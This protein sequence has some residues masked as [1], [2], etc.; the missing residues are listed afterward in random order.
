MKLFTVLR[1]FQLSV[2]NSCSYFVNKTYALGQTFVENIL[3]VTNLFALYTCSIKTGTFCLVNSDIETDEKEIR[4]E[5]E[6]KTM[7]TN[8]NYAPIC[9]IA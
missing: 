6:W 3:Q 9:S 1:S 8:Q 5:C 7:T 2:I 4:S